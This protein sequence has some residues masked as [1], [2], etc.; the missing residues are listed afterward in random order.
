VTILAQVPKICKSPGFHEVKPMHARLMDIY[1][2][3]CIMGGG[4]VFDM[5]AA[6]KGQR[7]SRNTRFPA[8]I[9][10]ATRITSTPW[11]RRTLSNPEV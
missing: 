7:R 10:T 6:P 11:E 5:T 3:L 1:R 9:W 8:A 2:L 4:L